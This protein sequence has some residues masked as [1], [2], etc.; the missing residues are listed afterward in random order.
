MVRRNHGGAYILR[1]ELGEEMSPARTIDMLKVIGES[2][3]RKQPRNVEVQ[4]QQQ[5]QQIYEVEKIVA[6]R[7]RRNRYEYCVKWKGYDKLTWEPYENFNGKKVIIQY[8][9]N[10]SK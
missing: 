1:N 2:N 10:R 8:W 3:S 6:H 5:D 9:R 7:F 4:K